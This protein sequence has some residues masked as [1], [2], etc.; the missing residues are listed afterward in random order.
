MNDEEIAII[1]N[2]KPAAAVTTT[3]AITI[4]YVLAIAIAAKMF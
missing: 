3:A 2:S 4:T 1:K